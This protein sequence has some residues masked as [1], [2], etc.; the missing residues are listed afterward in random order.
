[1]NNPNPQYYVA[2]AQ[3]DIGFTLKIIVN[4]TT[5]TARIF[6]LE[7]AVKE[8]RAQQRS[9]VVATYLPVV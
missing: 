3:A 4:L 9:G 6:S 2:V 1:M 5:R 7:Q 8:C